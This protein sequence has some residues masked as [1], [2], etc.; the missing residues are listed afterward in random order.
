MFRDCERAE[1]EQPV[2][3]SLQS[4]AWQQLLLRVPDAIREMRQGA[5][6]ANA[7]TLLGEIVNILIR[8]Q[9]RTT[10]ADMSEPPTAMFMPP[11]RCN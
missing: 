11:A 8:M 1:A 10:A 6:S 3:A 7:M 2:P 4:D 5:A 9:L